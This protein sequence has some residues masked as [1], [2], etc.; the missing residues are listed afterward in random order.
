MTKINY[1]SDTSDSRVPF[2]GRPVRSEVVRENFQVLANAGSLWAYDTVSPVAKDSATGDNLITRTGS[3]VTVTT[4][5][6]HELQVG[7]QVRITGSDGAT[8]D[9][10]GLFDVTSVLDA[11]SF[12][13]DIGVLTPPSPATG[14]IKVRHHNKVGVTKGSYQIAGTSNHEFAGG[15]SVELDL[16]TG[17]N[18]PD[19]AAVF[20]A[21]GESFVAVL[22]INAA[23]TLA[24]TKGNKSA[25][26]PTPPSF[27]ANQI[28]IVEVLVNYDSVLLGTGPDENSLGISEGSTATLVGAMSSAT[29]TVT[30][31]DHG[32]LAGE[33]IRITDVD[34]IAGDSA[35]AYEE[36]FHTIVAVVDKDTF[37]YTVGVPFTVNS[38]ANGVVND[39][40][41]D[42][43]PLINLGGGGGGGGGNFWSDPVDSD[44]IPVGANNAFDIGSAAFKFKDGY[45]AGKLTVDGPIDPTYMQLTAIAATS[46]PD[47]SFFLDA[48]D[49]IMKFKDNT[50]VVFAVGSQNAP[51]EYDADTVTDY[52]TGLP[53]GERDQI[54][55]A[56][57]STGN[58]TIE[59]LIVKVE[60]TDFDNLGSGSVL[61]EIF[62]DQPR[63]TPVFQRVFDLSQTPLIDTIP[64]YFKSDN[65]AGSGAIYIDITN[66]TG[67][68]GRF[69]VNVRTANLIP[70]TV[71]PVGSGS[72]VNTTVAGD[73]ILFNGLELGVELTPTISG[74]ELIG[75]SPNRTLQVKVGDG[76]QKTASGTEVDSTV[77]RT[78]GDQ[79]MAGQKRFTDS[80]F[81]LT[82]ASS[83]GPP[84]S[85]TFAE[86]DF[87]LD[88]N[89]NLFQCIAAGTPGAW[90][91]YGNSFEQN[92]D[93]GIAAGEDNATYTA[94][95]TGGG[96]LNVEVSTGIS[97]NADSGRRGVF[98]K[99][100]V[101]GAEA[102]SGGD[103]DTIQTG[104]IDQAFRIKCF[105]NENRFGREQLWMVAGQI[106]KTDITGAVSG[107]V[108]NVIPVS[109]VATGAPDDLVRLR[110]FAATVGEEYG[111]ITVRNTS[112]VQYELDEAVLNSFAANDPFMLVTEFVELPWLNNS[113]I[114]ANRD[115][116]FLRFLN[117]G[118][119]D[120]IFGFQFDL[121]SLGGGSSF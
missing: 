40:M 39:F 50:S 62:N 81:G 80:V 102:T 49:N 51:A 43:R 59:G 98:R 31:E 36:G 28:P 53:D 84:T 73:G 16:G 14:S 101:W 100:N 70:T 42:V 112:P 56:S 117:D 120:L 55:I 113:S 86:G 119:T 106:R 37:T 108:D 2:A 13:Y 3:N 64:T 65:V 18:I 116:I 110:R 1:L 71:P 76:I 29:V 44:I 20:M 52:P 72:G 79:N 7:D 95:V 22:S 83:V 23:G 104:E 5:E 97:I 85:G 105:P 48:A 114:G 77:I 63:V 47:H 99:L 94:I 115:K 68:T 69:Q 66:N 38:S 24:W 107:G 26:T 103:P 35:A 34:P 89:R 4:G 41:A 15:I 30:L 109:S 19:G 87:Y 54:D 25:G 118:A 11:F 74:L 10:N 58:A 27:P 90:Q 61:V 93:L 8:T 67:S 121:E 96:S 88:L 45:F 9:Y 33:T 60:L 6:K 92:I 12:V 46:V 91:F 57:P 75:A 111:R 17:G 78:T 82:P 21:S 32:F